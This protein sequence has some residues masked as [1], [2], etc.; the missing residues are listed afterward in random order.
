M[1]TNGGSDP[2]DLHYEFN[3]LSLVDLLRARTLADVARGQV[4]GGRAAE[5]GDHEEDRERDSRDDEE[6]DYCSDHPADQICEH[7]GRRGGR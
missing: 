7:R 4:V 1:A 6:Q 3:Q 5:L 2:L